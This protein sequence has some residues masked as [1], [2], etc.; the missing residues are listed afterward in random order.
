MVK[1]C[2]KCE[3]IVINPQKM[4]NQEV[5]LEHGNIVLNCSKIDLEYEHEDIYPN[6]PALK[7]SATAGCE[8]CN[9]LRD[10]FRYHLGEEP[11]SVLI[12]HNILE[13]DPFVKIH[14]LQYLWRNH[15]FIDNQVPNESDGLYVLRVSIDNKNTAEG[16]PWKNSKF[17]IGLG[18]YAE[19]NVTASSGAVY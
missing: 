1:L 13:K 2:K 12:Y 9:L 18:G 11:N 16:E 7:D 8:F 3:V 19:F 4:R 17:G 14:R 10:A 15:L 6:F 5:V